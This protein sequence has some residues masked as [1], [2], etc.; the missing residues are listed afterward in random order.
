MPEII[1]VFID[2]PSTRILIKNHKHNIT[3]GAAEILGTK[4]SEVSLR[5]VP[6]S[7]EDMEL[8]SNV[9]MLR[10][11]VDIDRKLAV[12]GQAKKIKDMIFGLRGF[13][14]VPFFDVWHRSHASSY[15][16]AM[17]SSNT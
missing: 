3:A 5:S 7:G 17:A 9:P 11:Y 1:A 2:L 4:A 8:S 6:L 12:R 16:V 15:A 13:E 14:R 10:F